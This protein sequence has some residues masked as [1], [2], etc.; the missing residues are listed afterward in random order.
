LER[1]LGRQKAA[2]ARAHKILVII[3]H[4]LMDGTFYDESRYDRQDA[5][6]EERDKKRALATLE[7]LGYHVTLSPVTVAAKA[8]TT[9]FHHC[10][11]SSPFTD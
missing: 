4:M 1:R 8:P 11:S 6:Q 5:R 7:R 2:M 10:R 9:S 3:Y